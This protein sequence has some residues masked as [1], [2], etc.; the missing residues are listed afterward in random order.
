[1]KFA[2]EMGSGAIICIS[3]FIKIGPDNQKLIGAIHRHKERMVI[4]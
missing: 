2:V 3:S 1:M 4:A